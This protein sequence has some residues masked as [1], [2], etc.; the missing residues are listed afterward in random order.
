MSSGDCEERGGRKRKGEREK[1]GKEG[2]KGRRELLVWKHFRRL[3]R[4]FNV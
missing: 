3:S 4:H 2:E 1:E